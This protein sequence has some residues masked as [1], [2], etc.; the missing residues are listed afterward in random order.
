MAHECHQKNTGGDHRKGFLLCV[1]AFA[2]T[3]IIG[4]RKVPANAITAQRCGLEM[5]IEDTPNFIAFGRPSVGRPKSQVET[6]WLSRCGMAQSSCE[7]IAISRHGTFLP[8][9]GWS[10]ILAHSADANRF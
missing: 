8:C 2:G 9:T 6:G 4:A 1:K 5:N 10:V 7:A 3:A